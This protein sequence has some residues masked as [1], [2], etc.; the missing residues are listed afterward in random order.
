MPSLA[1]LQ[2]KASKRQ[3]KNQIERRESFWKK[4]RS[5][6]P[7][8][9]VHFEESSRTAEHANGK[10]IDRSLGQIDFDD[11]TEFGNEKSFDLQVSIKFI[12]IVKA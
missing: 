5:Q 2:L 3:T 4:P 7:S 9:K 6:S 10:N 1:R 8:K 12:L 11:T